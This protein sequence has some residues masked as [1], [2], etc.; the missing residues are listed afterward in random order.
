MTVKKV[1]L[2]ALLSLYFLS[3]VSQETE[4]ID[5][6]DNAIYLGNRIAGG[7]GEWRF[8]GEIQ[9]RFKNDFKSLDNWYLEGIASRLLTK[10]WQAQFS[11]RYSFK[12]TFNELRP[13]LGVFY[14]MYPNE[15]TQLAHQVMYQTDISSQEVR[16]GLRYVLYYTYKASEKLVPN[17]TMGV[18]YRWQDDFKGVQFV[19]A[20]PGL[21]YLIDIKHFI[22]FNYFV[23]FENRGDVWT[24]QGIFF[25]QLIININKDYK[26]LPARSVQF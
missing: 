9:T 6:W 25:V 15:K 2:T 21:T 20:G 16:H 19:R 8:S 1:L 12:P 11:L 3:L 24:Y 4:P 13:G 23:G 17:A 10:N 7:T 22:N 26:Y 5:K 14:K 18:F